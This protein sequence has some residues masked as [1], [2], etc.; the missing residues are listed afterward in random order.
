MIDELEEIPVGESKDLS[1]NL[2]AG[3]YVLICNIFQEPEDSHYQF[4]MR[5]GF[6]VE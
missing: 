4:G 2:E 6:E 3:S 5:I 1:V